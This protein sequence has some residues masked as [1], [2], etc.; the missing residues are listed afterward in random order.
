MT[1]ETKQEESFLNLGGANF[2]SFAH[3]AEKPIEENNGNED[4]TEESSEIKDKE[5]IIQDPPV[6]ED[7]KL[8]PEVEPKSE[9]GKLIKDF[10]DNGVFSYNEENE[11]ED[12]KEGFDK[13]LNE[14]FQKRESEAILKY[15]ESLGKDGQKLLDHL[16]QGYTVDQ[17]IADK[18]EYY[19]YDSMDISNMSEDDKLTLIEFLYEKQGFNEDEISTQI[20][21]FK[22][23]K[24]VDIMA[25]KA[26]NKLKEIQEKDIYAKEEKRK[27]DLQITEENKVKAK[28]ELKKTVLSKRQIKGI[29]ITEKDALE[30]YDYIT[31][32]IDKS[33]RTKLQMDD[34]DENRLFYAYLGMKGFD[35][36][37]LMDKAERK[38]GIKLKTSL[39][40]SNN[41]TLSSSYK[42][43]IEND[44]KNTYSQNQE[45]IFKALKFATQR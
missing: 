17:Y 7:S 31:K 30:L 28:E 44:S 4:S 19:D 25:E 37:K 9:W 14:N 32:P 38:V 13:L 10:V 39:D 33:N 42:G 6:E 34:N 22:I 40:T 8:I 5:P 26:L 36:K 2:S 24:N 16:A 20:D 29:D 23:A 43:S 27:L 3:L 45:D 18:Q 15:K 1:T 41:K 11:Y 12:S 21:A 35:F